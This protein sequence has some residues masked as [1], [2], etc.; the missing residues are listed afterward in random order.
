[1]NKQNVLTTIQKV[2]DQSQKRK[3]EQSVD[4]IVNFKGIDFK[5][6]QNRIDTN[7]NMP[8]GSGKTE[9]KALVFVRDKHFA[10]QL[11]DKVQ[12]IV[13]EDE[14]E[15]LAKSKKEVQQILE[16]YN[17][18]L[19]EGPVILTVA[20][21][22]GQ[23]LAPKGKMPKPVQA[24]IREVES[25]IS[26]M[27]SSVRITNKKGKFMPLVNLS[28][29][30]ETMKDEQ[31][32]ENTLAVYNAILSALNNNTQSIKSVILKTTMGPAVKITEDEA[33]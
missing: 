18:L 33:Q 12:K 28:V 9:S 5:K 8:F 31:L 24:N 11:K 25:I 16:E 22:L 2:R 27:G 4:L 23:Q 1:M 20:K 6:E 26:S 13:L 14:I 19:A 29:G 15:A 32:A 7:V 17:V 10:E 21:F 3:F 30:K